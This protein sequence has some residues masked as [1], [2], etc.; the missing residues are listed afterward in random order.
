MPVDTTTY[1]STSAYDATSF[2]FHEV[3][4]ALESLDITLEQV[5][6]K[7]LDSVD[8]HV[9]HEQKYLVSLLFLTLFLYS[10]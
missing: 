2:I 5:L 6:R 3:A 10:G 8:M 7:I 1:C 9:W 4:A